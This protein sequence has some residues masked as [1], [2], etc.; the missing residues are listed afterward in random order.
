MAAPVENLDCTGLDA[1]KL[2]G[3]RHCRITDQPRAGARLRSK[4]DTAAAMF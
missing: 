3:A 1:A 2:L 4:S